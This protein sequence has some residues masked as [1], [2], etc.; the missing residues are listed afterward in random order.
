MSSI[1]V[2]DYFYT[3]HEVSW[4]HIVLS[5][6]F[7]D[8]LAGTEAD[9]SSRGQ[10]ETVPGGVVFTYKPRDDPTRVLRCFYKL[11]DVQLSCSRKYRPFCFTYICLFFRITSRTSSQG[12]FKHCNAAGFAYFGLEFGFLCAC[13][14]MLPSTSLMVADDQCSMVRRGLHSPPSYTILT[15]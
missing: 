8:L 12:C 2:V 13:G 15:L 3:S 4:F 11:K 1:P 14:N 7:D 10:K 5:I 9:D 6:E